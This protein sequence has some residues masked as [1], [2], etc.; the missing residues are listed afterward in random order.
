MTHHLMSKDSPVNRIILLRNHQ[1]TNKDGIAIDL[2]S[3]RKGIWC[4]EA[5]SSDLIDQIDPV[6]GAL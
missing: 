4:A 5:Y 2:N 3:D 6:K 1:V